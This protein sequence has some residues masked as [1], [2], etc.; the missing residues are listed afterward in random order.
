MHLLNGELHK[1]SYTKELVN[2]IIFI[3]QTIINIRESSIYLKKMMQ[4]F[5]HLIC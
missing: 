1:K 5:Q 2:F 3:M 4:V